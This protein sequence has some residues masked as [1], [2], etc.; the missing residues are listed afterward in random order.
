MKRAKAEG[1]FK[2]IV[3]MDDIKRLKP[4]PDGLLKILAGR[5]PAGALY[6]GDNVDDAL[7]SQ[8]AHVP[9]LGVLPRNSHPRRLRGERLRELGALKILHNVSEAEKW[10]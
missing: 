6:L 5:D 10:L 9:F 7:A 4:H 8:R 1:L 3:T 2:R